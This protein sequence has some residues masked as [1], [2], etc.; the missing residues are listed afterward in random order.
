M[1]GRDITRP[2]GTTY[3]EQLA[4]GTALAVGVIYRDGEHRVVLVTPASRREEALSV[5]SMWST[6]GSG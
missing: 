5:Q 3:R 6:R 4:I 2:V 1:V